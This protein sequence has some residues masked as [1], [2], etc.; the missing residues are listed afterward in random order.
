MMQA[1]A[2]RPARGWFQ[3]TRSLLS[4]SAPIMVAQGGLV[5]LGITDTFMIGQV[6][7][8]E[9]G[10]VALGNIITLVFLVFGL[11]LAMGIEPL[12]S[13]ANGAG[14]TDDAFRWFQQGVWVA[15]L[16][17]LPVV[18][19]VVGCLL[20]LPALG[21][22]EAIIGATAPYVWLRMPSIPFNSMYGASR[23]YLTSVQRTRPVA[24][25]VVVANVANVGLDYY[26]LFVLDLGAGGIGAAT[27]ICWALM[28]GIATAAA[29]MGRPPGVRFFCRPDVAQIQRIFRI[30]WPIG[31]M[32]MAEVGVFSFVGLLVARMG[33]V[34]LAGHQIAITLASFTFMCAAGL[35]VGTTS[36]VGNHVGAGDTA[37]ARRVGGLGILLGGLF[38]GLG[39]VLFWLFDTPLARLFSP[40]DETVVRVG[41]DLL[42]IAA[43]FSVSDGL[44]VVSAGALRGIGDTKWSFYANTGAHWLVGLPLGLYLANL[45]GFGVRGLWLGLTVGL[46][47]VAIILTYRFFRLT[48]APVERVE[49]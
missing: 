35:A 39:G 5:A 25:A 47:G 27:S 30:G 48:R 14:E 41:A 37:S 29:Y 21:V 31:L 15:M 49:E 26:F 28:F 3:Q 9:M 10:G 12:A 32:F 20:A 24:L 11:G 33:A 34:D 8:V 38:M 19:L 7:S 22:S 16:S 13:Q 23:S 43:L 46:T 2:E 45:A 17:S 18:G 4:L 44:Q 36:L 1:P 42:R 6:S 40:T